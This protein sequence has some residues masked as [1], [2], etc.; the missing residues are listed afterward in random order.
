MSSEKEGA[1]YR[2]R[3]AVRR[4][5]EGIARPKR[6]QNELVELSAWSFM[7]T[8]S[9]RVPPCSSFSLR[10]PDAPGTVLPFRTHARTHAH[11]RTL[12]RTLSTSKNP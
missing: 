4:G 3:R 11:Y 2:D 12:D 8:G 7:G 10:N 5:G 6:D 9:D 1:K